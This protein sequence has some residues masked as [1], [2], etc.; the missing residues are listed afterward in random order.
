MWKWFYQLLLDI[1]LFVPMLE[2]LVFSR[3]IIKSWSMVSSWWG[4]GSNLC[5]SWGIAL[6]FSRHY[7]NGFACNN[8]S[9]DTTKW[10]AYEKTCGHINWNDFNSQRLKVL[11][12]K[13][14]YAR[15]CL[16][17]KTMKHNMV[18]KICINISARIYASSY[19]RCYVLIS[20]LQKM[21]S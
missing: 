15:C 5:I 12:W 7:I 13:S 16:F 1:H 8:A 20:F 21:Y 19:C 17:P 2:R 6:I 10:M 9:P 11:Y 3:T 4:L 18:L 14:I